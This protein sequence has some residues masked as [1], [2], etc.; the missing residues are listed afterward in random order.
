LPR[1]RVLNAGQEAL[2]IEFAG[3]RLPRA[4]RGHL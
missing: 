1:L 4:A 2:P 3:T